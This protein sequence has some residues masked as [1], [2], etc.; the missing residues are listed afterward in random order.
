MDGGKC[1]KHKESRI[2]SGTSSIFSYD[3]WCVLEFQGFVTVMRKEG[4]LFSVRPSTRNNLY[5]HTYTRRMTESF[6]CTNKSALWQCLPLSQYSIHAQTLDC[7]VAKIS[8]LPPSPEQSPS[9][10]CQHISPYV[11]LNTPWHG[12]SVFQQRKIL[13]EYQKTSW[14]THSMYR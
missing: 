2:N 6:T 10:L 5:A 14:T 4:I 12:K 13:S 9:V 7:L 1:R 11:Q 3:T 8:T